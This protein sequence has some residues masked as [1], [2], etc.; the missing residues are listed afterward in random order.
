MEYTGRIQ[1]KVGVVYAPAVRSLSF[2]EKRNT[3]NLLHA[4]G[5]NG[6]VEGQATYTW[7]LTCSLTKDKQA[8]LALIDQAKRDGEV[9]LTFIW[10]ANEFMLINCARGG[11]SFTSDSDAEASLT[12]SGIA[13]SMLQTR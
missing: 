10:G 4:N 5:D 11:S 8:I 13:A 12:I 6:V 1:V 7:S 2:E 9:T 3:K